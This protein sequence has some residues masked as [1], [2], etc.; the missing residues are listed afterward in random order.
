M[1]RRHI[2]EVPHMLN[3]FGTQ[4]LDSNKNYTINQNQQFAMTSPP[5]LLGA[6]GFATQNMPNQQS[7]PQSFISN[8]ANI[9]N[10]LGTVR[11]DLFYFFYLKKKCLFF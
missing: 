8:A 5:N 6:P 2:A 11:V 7:L 1:Y 10:P 9:S 4:Q 3:A